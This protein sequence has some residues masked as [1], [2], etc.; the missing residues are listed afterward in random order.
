MKELKVGDRVVLSVLG[1]KTY[2]QS[3]V[4]PHKTPGNILKVLPP[5]TAGRRV[6]VK[7]NNGQTNTYFPHELEPSIVTQQLDKTWVESLSTEQKKNLL[8]MLEEDANTE[9]VVLFSVAGKKWGKKRY[10]E[11][12]LKM[13]Y[14][15]FKGQIQGRPVI[16][17]L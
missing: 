9:E 11:S 16:T 12:K 15:L 3:Y 14:T 5:S 2:T 8:R 13:T 1:R 17:K 10:P 4:H 7:W 6:H